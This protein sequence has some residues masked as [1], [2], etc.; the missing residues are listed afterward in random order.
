M[1]VYTAYGKRGSPPKIPPNAPLEFEIE[2]LE[3]SK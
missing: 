3:I 1:S 2:L